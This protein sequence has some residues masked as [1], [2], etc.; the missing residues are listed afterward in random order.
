MMFTRRLAGTPGLQGLGFC[1]AK[2]G[3]PP[4]SE[5][6]GRDPRVRVRDSEGR[7]L[8]S[9]V[10]D[11]T[12]TGAERAPQGQQVGTPGTG[13]GP[14]AGEEDTAR[15]AARQTAQAVVRISPQA[16]QPRATADRA[17]ST[18]T[19]VIPTR[20]HRASQDVGMPPSPLP[21]S[22]RAR[23]T[24]FPGTPPRATSRCAAAA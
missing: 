14:E 11:R 23:S 10:A 6:C 9:L 7:D 21:G 24:V 8:D 12:E 1:S 19:G 18:V 5:V 17:L 15:G 16:T 20:P 4:G 2:G 13:Q 22:G 3:D